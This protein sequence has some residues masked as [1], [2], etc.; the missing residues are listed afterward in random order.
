MKWYKK[1]LEQILKDKP[2]SVLE[3]SKTIIKRPLVAK[4]TKI[5][6]SSLPD[7]VGASKLKRPKTFAP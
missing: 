2:E 3:N 7:P 1:Q 4:K 5:K 6:N